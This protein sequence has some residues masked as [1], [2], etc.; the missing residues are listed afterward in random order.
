M[1]VRDLSRRKSLPSYFGSGTVSLSC[2]FCLFVGSGTLSLP[3]L[4]FAE[5]R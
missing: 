4:S 1:Q 2:H 3:C 5:L